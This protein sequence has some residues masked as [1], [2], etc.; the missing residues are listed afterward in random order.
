M[1][2]ERPTE[3]RGALPAFPAHPVRVMAW[4][5]D[6]CA[7]LTR[8]A[9]RELEG[10]T[11]EDPAYWR[12]VISEAFRAD[13]YA[14]AG[15]MPVADPPTHPIPL[16]TRVHVTRD[17]TRQPWDARVIRHDRN[18]AYRLELT[19]P[20]IGD[21]RSYVSAYGWELSERGDA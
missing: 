11:G 5:A 2:P 9:V 6:G 12:H 16:G 19:H 8:A 14:V 21:G 13:L 17:G 18:G 10:L 7:V 4:T 15:L 3:S 1:T 20:G